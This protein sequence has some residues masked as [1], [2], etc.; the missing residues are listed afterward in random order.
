MS[1]KILDL[2]KDALEPE[3]TKEIKIKK[4]NFANLAG[5]NKNFVETVA[6]AKKAARISASVFVYGETGTGKE[7]IA[8]SIHFDSNRRD[9]PFLAQ[10][11]AALPESLLEGNFIRTARG[12]FTGCD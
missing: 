1:N 5:Q 4:Y 7:L 9:K 8:Q 6:I 10:N 11:C 12:G 2:H 3:K